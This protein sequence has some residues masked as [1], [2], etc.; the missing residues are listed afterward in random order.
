VK[1]VLFQT[2]ANGEVV[3]GVMTDRGVGRH[4]RCREKKGTTPQLTMQG[5]IDGFDGIEGPRW[6]SSPLE[7]KGGWAGRP[8]PAQRRR[9]RVRAKIL[10]CIAKLLGTRP[11]RR[12]ARLN[13][14]MKNPDAVIGPGDTIYAA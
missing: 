14:F 3:P 4:F 6:R 8:G 11:A 9:C 7:G 10:C 1:L 13:M 12:N 2:A 5:I